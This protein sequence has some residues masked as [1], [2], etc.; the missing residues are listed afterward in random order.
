MYNI[1]QI[2]GCIMYTT[3]LSKKCNIMVRRTNNYCMLL[4]IF[5]TPEDAWDYEKD[6]EWVSKYSSVEDAKDFFINSIIEYSVDEMIEAANEGHAWPVQFNLVNKVVETCKMVAIDGFGIVIGFVNA[7]KGSK[8]VL[9]F[10][11]DEYEN[12]QFVRVSIAKKFVKKA[13]KTMKTLRS[14]TD[15]TGVACF[16]LDC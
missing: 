13:R 10:D 14:G 15:Q 5:G 2:E 6:A 3:N 8:S 11:N 7:P 1:E 9:V 16:Y 4:S 12:P